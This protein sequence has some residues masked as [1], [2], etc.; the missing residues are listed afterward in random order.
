MLI[1]LSFIY[2]LRKRKIIKSGK[3]VAYLAF[4]ETLGWFGA[5]LLFIHAGIHFNAVLPW[6]AV[7][8]MFFNVI[9]GLTG[10]LLLKKSVVFLNTTRADLENKGLN[11]SEVKKMLFWDAL[12]VGIMKKWRAVHLPI[13]IA[14]FTFAVIHIFSILIFW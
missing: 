12:A 5:L 13:A 7:I 1:V 14:F 9:S 2:S 6:L 10:K 8:F 11:Y 4:H 3:I